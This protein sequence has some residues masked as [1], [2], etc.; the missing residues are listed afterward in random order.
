MYVPSGAKP[1]SL[2]GSGLCSGKI[3]LKVG[4]PPHN[5]HTTLQSAINQALGGTREIRVQQR[6]DNPPGGLGMSDVP[7]RQRTVNTTVDQGEAVSFEGGYDC[8]FAVNTARYTV[9][10]GTATFDG[11]PVT[12]ENLVVR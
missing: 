8:S 6:T 3:I 2:G 12:L 5:T 7:G 4:T 11:G 9:L 10:D 1:P